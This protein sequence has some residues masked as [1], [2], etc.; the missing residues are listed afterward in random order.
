MNRDAMAVVIESERLVLFPYTAEGLALFNRDLAAFE[1]TYGVKYRGEE[2]DYL[3]TEFLVRLE[4]AVAADPEHYLFFTEFLI[5]RSE[6]DV[7]VGS[8]DFKYI[9]VDG[10]TEVGYG[11]NPVYQGNGYMTEALRA[12]LA[13]GKGLGVRQVKA[14]TLRDNVRSQRVLARCGFRQTEEIEDSL[15]WICTL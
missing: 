8:I 13:Y 6:D 2:L 12:F 3:L 5:V 9:P 10:V 14:E 4:K 11:L 1:R 7:V 15:W